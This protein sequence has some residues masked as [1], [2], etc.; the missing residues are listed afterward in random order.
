MREVKNTVCLRMVTAPTDPRREDGADKKKRL[1][2]SAIH[3]LRAA[4]HEVEHLRH[5]VSE[6]ESPAALAILIG[7]WI[8]IVVPLVGL[9]VALALAAADIATR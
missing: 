9:V 8:A 7:T 2:P 3:P 1:A 5:I 6:G 4:V